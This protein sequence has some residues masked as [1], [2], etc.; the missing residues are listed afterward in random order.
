MP[1]KAVS[2]TLQASEKHSMHAKGKQKSSS[3]GPQTDIIRHEELQGRHVE[4]APIGAQGMG[5]APMQPGIGGCGAH[6]GG[7]DGAIPMVTVI[8]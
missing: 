2:L 4:H 1:V 6:P 5:P 3:S 8:L 7:A